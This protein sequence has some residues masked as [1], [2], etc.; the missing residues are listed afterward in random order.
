MSDNFIEDFFYCDLHL[1]ENNAF[2][3]LKMQW[4][5][6]EA[7][8]SDESSKMATDEVLPVASEKVMENGSASDNVECVICGDSMPLLN[9]VNHQQLA[10]A[11]IRNIL[12][13]LNAVASSWKR[14]TA[15]RM[16]RC[17]FCHNTMPRSS[18]EKHQMK[19]H[20]TEFIRMQMQRP[21]ISSVQTRP[22]HLPIGS[23]RSSFSTSMSTNKR[24]YY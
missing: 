2:C 18:L 24:K 16:V 8:K 20:S 17:K 15:M 4:T 23:I 9:L 11:N 12:P 19:K 3:A 22:T 14:T 7:V 10:H 5:S 6:W 21:Y 13:Q 1:F